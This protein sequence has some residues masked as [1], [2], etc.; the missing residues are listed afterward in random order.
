M[1]LWHYNSAARL[2]SNITMRAMDILLAFPSYLLAIAIVAFLGTGLEKG[3][4][5]IGIVGIPVFAR[6]VRSLG[7]LRSAKKCI[8]LPP[9]SR[10]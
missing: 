5:A 6:A 4:I 3:M 1:Q 9:E 7:A 2:F 10:W 8:S